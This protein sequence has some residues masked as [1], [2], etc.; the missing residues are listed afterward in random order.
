MIVIAS[1]TGGP[2]ALAKLLS[3]IPATIPVAIVIA[4]HMPPVFTRCLAE[5][6]DATSP[7]T[8]REA[9]GGERDDVS[10]VEEGALAVSRVS[11]K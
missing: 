2:D 11:I 4:Q 9:Q 6:L 5:R 1:S 8:V 3:L 10:A 7:L